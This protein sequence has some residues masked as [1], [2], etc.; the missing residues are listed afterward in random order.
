MEIQLTKK[1]AELI[2]H[3]IVCCFRSIQYYSR[4]VAK[5]GEFTFKNFDKFG[6]S[7]FDLGEAGITDYEFKSYFNILKKLTA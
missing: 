5:K 4:S 3:E 7:D 2:I 6:K 1:E